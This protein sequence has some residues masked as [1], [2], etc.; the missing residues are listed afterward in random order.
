MNI[1]NM[2]MGISLLR[3]CF[4]NKYT[5]FCFTIYLINTIWLSLELTMP[6]IHSTGAE[7]RKVEENSVD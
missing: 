5:V 7:W 2:I 1:T 4:S 3:V 6:Q